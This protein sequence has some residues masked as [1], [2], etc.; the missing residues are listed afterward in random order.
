[1][2]YYAVPFMLGILPRALQI[3][4]TFAQPFLVDA[5][6][7]WIDAPDEPYTMNQG[8]GLIGAFAIVYIGIAVSAT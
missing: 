1:M 8:Y 2:K 6:T 7:T 5:T 3:G 4:F